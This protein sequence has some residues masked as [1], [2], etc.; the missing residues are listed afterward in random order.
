MKS[1]RL[2]KGLEALIPQVSPDDQSEKTEALYEVAVSEIKPNSLQPRHEF[3]REK[4]DQLKQSI[5]E[6]GVIQPVTVRKVDGFY[7]LIAGER[8]FRAV[9]ELGFKKVPAYVIDV[10]SDEKM[11]EMALIENIQR[12]DL[13]AI[14]IAKAYQRLQKEYGLTQEEVSQKVGKERAT[15]ANFI[16][17]LKLPEPIQE[18]IQKDEISMGHARALMGLNTRG[19]QIDL[20]KK[21]LKNGLNVRK[22]ETLVRDAASDTNDKK[23]FKQSE[24]SSFIVECENTLRSALGTQVQIKPG[25]KGGKIEVAYFSDDELERL[26]ELIQSVE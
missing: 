5:L 20:W 17:L 9:S 11:L 13:N 22:V 26:L 4:L 6:N 2:G 16:R 10:E 1:K 15:V 21:I 7:E 19:Q 24:K 3:D 12:D 14:E 25:H 23:A 8:R 18:S